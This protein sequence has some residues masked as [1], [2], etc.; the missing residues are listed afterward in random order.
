MENLPVEMV[1]RIA[2]FLPPPCSSPDLANA[3]AA[4]GKKLPVGAIQTQC[5][6]FD[7]LRYVE[8]KC[9]THSPPLHVKHAAEIDKALAK[10]FRNAKLLR[11]IRFSSLEA[12]KVACTIAGDYV[13]PGMTCCGGMGMRLRTH[14]SRCASCDHEP[15][16]AGCTTS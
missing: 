12:A 13:D 2:D 15:N 14:D 11:F 6:P 16:M 9:V 3:S 8:I 5:I 10:H 4:W 1:R 7:G